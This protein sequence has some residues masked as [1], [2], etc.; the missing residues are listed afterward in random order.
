MES[1]NAQQKAHFIQEL[2]Q[3]YNQDTTNLFLSYCVSG[4]YSL[5]ESALSKDG[6]DTFHA[7]VRCQQVLLHHREYLAYRLGL[8]HSKI[9]QDI[10]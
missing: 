6:L 1:L 10:K 2:E 4:A 8:Q 5:H 3:L 9:S 7:Y